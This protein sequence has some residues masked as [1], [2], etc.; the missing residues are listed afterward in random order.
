MS[1]CGS[2]WKLK[3]AMPG[4]SEVLQPSGSR[5]EPVLGWRYGAVTIEG[6]RQHGQ[7]DM[8][9]EKGES[10]GKTNTEEKTSATETWG[11]DPR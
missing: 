6:L 2:A 4:M 3:Q 1:S 7:F 5:E 10:N 8:I 11:I 9:T